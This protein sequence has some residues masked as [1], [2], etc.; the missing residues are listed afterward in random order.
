MSRLFPISV[1]T[2]NWKVKLSLLARSF[3]IVALSYPDNILDAYFE[4]LQSRGM[5]SITLAII[6]YVRV[7]FTGST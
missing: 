5:S 1:E 3:F 7:R 6:I 4:K 2:G